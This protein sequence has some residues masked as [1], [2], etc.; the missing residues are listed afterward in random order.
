MHVNKEK[1]LFQTRHRDKHRIDKQTLVKDK[2]AV[3]CCCP[4][5]LPSGKT[6]APQIDTSV[7]VHG[8]VLIIIN[9]Y[10]TCIYAAHR[11]TDDQS[12]AEMFEFGGS[13][14]IRPAV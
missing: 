2:V 8:C 3:C 10:Y 6:S 1:F 5:G 14:C 4:G 12:A 9:K 7:Y 11:Y 13:V